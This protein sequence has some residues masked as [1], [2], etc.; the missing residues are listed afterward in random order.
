MRPLLSNAKR[1]F[2]LNFASCGWVGM[3]L[4][5]ATGEPVATLDRV[6][7]LVRRKKTVTL[8]KAGFSG[9]SDHALVTDG[10]LSGEAVRE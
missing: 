9:W 8:R 1:Q 10:I 5:P 6:L 2:R 7:L 3:V 4:D